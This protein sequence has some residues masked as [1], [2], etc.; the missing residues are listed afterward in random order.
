MHQEYGVA[1]V[2]LRK[3]ASNNDVPFFGERDGRVIYIFDKD[4]EERFKN[5]K[6]GRNRNPI[7]AKIAVQFGVSRQCVS[8]WA[9]KNDIPKDENGYVFGKNEIALFKHR[10]EDVQRG[11]PRKENHEPEKRPPVLSKNGRPLGRPRKEK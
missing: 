1:E 8:K 9:K 6:D 4:S 10:N 3:W 11:R 7:I 5:R 2:T